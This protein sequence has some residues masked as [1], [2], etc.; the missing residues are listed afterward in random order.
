MRK[1][2]EGQLTLEDFDLFTENNNTEKKEKPF[3]KDIEDM[4]TD[5][6]KAMSDEQIK[7]LAAAFEKSEEKEDT[8]ES[9]FSYTITEKVDGLY[10]VVTEDGNIIKEKTATLSEEEYLTKWANKIISSKLFSR[11]VAQYK[12]S[13]IHS[14]ATLPAGDC[15]YESVI[16]RATEEEIRITLEILEKY[17]ANNSSRIRRCKRQL[18]EI[19]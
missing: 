13:N 2:L 19:A 6:I 8:A 9:D 18:K 15:N 11:E 5:S 4:V 7:T 10:C 12:N 14:L 3:W 17:P 16:N 1:T